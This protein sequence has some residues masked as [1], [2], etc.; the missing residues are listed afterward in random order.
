MTRK[1][2]KMYACKTIAFWGALMLVFSGV[3]TY[4][5]D[6]NDEELEIKLVSF[7]SLSFFAG[8]YYINQHLK[9]AKYRAKKAGFIYDGYSLENDFYRYGEA[10]VRVY[11]STSQI[12]LIEPIA[13]NEKR[14]FFTDFEPVKLWANEFAKTGEFYNRYL[15]DK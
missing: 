11:K 8:I 3:L 4:L 2:E 14:V 5:I 9:S 7:I 6:L 10:R 1:S 13:P 15:P 12:E